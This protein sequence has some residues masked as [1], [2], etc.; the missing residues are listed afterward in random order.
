MVPRGTIEV[1]LMVERARRWFMES[2]PPGR[3]KKLLALSKKTREGYEQEA[4]SEAASVAF[5]VD[6][7]ARGDREAFERLVA[8]FWGDIFRLAYYRTS[9]RDDAEELAQ[10]IFMK[11]FNNIG[12]LKE[13]EKFKSW[14]YSIGLNR[15]RDYYRRKKVRSIITLFFGRRGPGRDSGDQRPGPHGRGGS[16]KAGVLATGGGL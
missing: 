11:A 5:L 9:S 7:A 14:L 13:P 3:R 4:G 2:K 16:G 10:D 12:G 1:D 6:L 15:I 8:R